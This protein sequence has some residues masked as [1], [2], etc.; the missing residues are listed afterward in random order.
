MYDNGNVSRCD[1]PLSHRPAL[2]RRSHR[3]PKNMT[4]KAQ[5]GIRERL[6]DAVETTKNERGSPRATFGTQIL[7]CA[8]CPLTGL[9]LRASHALIAL[10]RQLYYA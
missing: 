4:G 9:A 10:L 8:S 6:G 5:I 3:V 2:I 7:S 1:L